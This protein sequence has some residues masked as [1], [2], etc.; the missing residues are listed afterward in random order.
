MH[1][2]ILT[3]SVVSQVV[4]ALQESDLS[5]DFGKLLIGL[6]N[7]KHPHLTRFSIEIRGRHEES[8]SL[9]VH[10]LYLVISKYLGLSF[11]LTVC[12]AHGD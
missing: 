4:R 2:G 7:S 9:R 5:A 11:P 8:Q 6:R 10:I 1:G 3:F 12:A